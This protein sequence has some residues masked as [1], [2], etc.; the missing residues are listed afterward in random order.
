M[1]QKIIAWC[2]Y[3]GIA[4]IGWIV[5]CSWMDR[6]SLYQSNVCVCMCVFFVWFFQKW[7]YGS[8]KKN[9][10]SLGR[11]EIR[12]ISRWILDGTTIARH[13]CWNDDNCQSWCM[14][15]IIIFLKKKSHIFILCYWIIHFLLL[16]LLLYLCQ[17]CR[18][19]STAWEGN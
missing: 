2:R 16:L 5:C 18:Y 11:R 15:A 19:E 17:L 13:S 7:V 9:C 1:F 10:F 6:I 3:Y 14:V 4:I 12:N 8:F